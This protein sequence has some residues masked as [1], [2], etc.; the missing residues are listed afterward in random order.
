MMRMTRRSMRMR[1]MTGMISIGS[2]MMRIM[3]IMRRMVNL[4]F[5]YDQ[6]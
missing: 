2:R 6:G 3:K 5:G 4:G 1:I